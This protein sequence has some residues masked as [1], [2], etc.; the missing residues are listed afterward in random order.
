MSVSMFRSLCSLGFGLTPWIY[1]LWRLKKWKSYSWL[2][3]FGSST[4]PGHLWKKTYLF[5][6]NDKVYRYFNYLVI[7]PNHLAAWNLF[8]AVETWLTDVVITKRLTAP[9]PG[10][11]KMPENCLRATTKTAIWSHDFSNMCYG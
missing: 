8:L 4:V 6:P 3:S 11:V 5:F 7:V 10:K 9:L 2:D 1:N